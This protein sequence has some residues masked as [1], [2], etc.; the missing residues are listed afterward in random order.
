MNADPS[1]MFVPLVFTHL[2]AC[3]A[4]GHEFLQRLAKKIGFRRGN[5]K[6]NHL[7]ARAFMENISC[8]LQRENSEMLSRRRSAA[9]M[10]L[11]GAVSVAG[12]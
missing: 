10:V 5:G 9:E 11:G 7:F 3:N 4:V 6:N 2:G 1:K 8:T 12:A